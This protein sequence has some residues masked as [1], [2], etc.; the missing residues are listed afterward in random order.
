MGHFKIGF[1]NLNEVDDAT[2]HVRQSLELTVAQY[3]DIEL[4][5]RDNQMDSVKAKENMQYFADIPVDL[6]VLF[7]LDERALADIIT[8]L[9]WKG[10]PTITMVVRT[11]MAYFFGLDDKQSGQLVGEELKQWIETN[12]DGGFDKL[13]VVTP[14][15]GLTFNHDRIE[16]AI[17]VLKT[18]PGYAS[19][20]V[21][22]IDE[23]GTA[24]SAT[25]N[26]QAVMEQWQGQHRVV[27]LS[28]IDYIA[29]AILDMIRDMGHL[30]QV[31]CGSF[32]GTPASFDEF[33]KPDSRLIV[34]P[35]FET[36]R[37]SEYLMA[38]T[39]DILNNKP[40]PDRSVRLS[41]IPH[42]RASFLLQDDGT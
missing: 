10:I 29:I 30:S 32:H 18:L 37:F 26:A 28:M 9:I 39:L 34:A 22:Y 19:K 11:P 15:K 25:A 2:I 24:A 38:M 31:V 6:A 13:L 35:I 33:R 12:W 3:N 8:P 16:T 1:A 36:H 27:I 17:D 7:H 5:L 20:N 4:I 23:G 42:T 21:L 41:P 40:I 14:Q